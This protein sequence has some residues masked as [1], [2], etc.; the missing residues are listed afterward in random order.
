M[1]RGLDLHE[2]AWQIIETGLWSFMTT[3]DLVVI[4]IYIPFASVHLAHA[5]IQSDFTMETGHSLSVQMSSR[6]D[7]TFY[8]RA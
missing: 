5:F 3:A 6:R 4:Y 2:E 1:W 8:L 7:E